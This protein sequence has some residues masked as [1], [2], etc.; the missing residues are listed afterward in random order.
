MSEKLRLE[1]LLVH[2]RTRSP[3][4]GGAVV[5]PIFQSSTFVFGGQ[6]DYHNVRYARLSNTPN[7]DVLHDKIAAIEGTE[8]A[9][10]TTSGMAAISTTLLA[11]LEAGDHLL[12]QDSLYGGTHDLVRED[13]P[14]LGIE[15]TFVDLDRPDTWQAA[16][17]PRSRA[18]YMESIT[19]PLFHVGDL[20]AAAAFAQT[21]HLCSIID[22]T[23]AT[24]VNF[25]PATLGVDLVVHSATKYLNGHTDIVAGAVAGSRAWVTRVKHKLDHLGGSLDAHACFLLERGLKTAALRV[26]HQN[27]SAL[28]IARYLAAHPKVAKVHYPG[29][30]SHPQHARAKALMTGFG[31]CLSFELKGDASYADAVMARLTLAISAPS[32]GG[33]E[34]LITRPATTSHAGVPP[35]VRRRLGITDTLVRLTVGLE[36]PEDLIADFAQA[37]G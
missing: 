10:V 17:K 23:F 25:Q 11:V 24:P 7:H 27:A 29:L 35:E 9:L 1:T 30:D 18:F 19:N 8:A 26:R 2:G 6:S 37:L 33:T 14:K 4:L 32:L 16:L 3:S 12:I 21:H 36:A 20:A 5:T 28:A 31:G 22:N 13:L 15:V 34:T